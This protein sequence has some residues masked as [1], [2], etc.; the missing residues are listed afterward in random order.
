MPWDQTQKFIRSGHKKPED[1]DPEILKTITLSERRRNPSH[2]RQT[3]EQ[4]YTKTW[5]TDSIFK[6]LDI[7][8][9]FSVDTGFQKKNI[10]KTFVVAESFQKSFTIQKQTD[11]LFRRFDVIKS[12][13]VDAHFGALMTQFL[14]RPI[15]VLLKKL[16]AT[17]TF[18]LDTCFG[19]VVSETYEKSFGLSFIFAYRV[20]LPE[21][22]LDE[23][24]KLVLN[25]SKPYVWVGT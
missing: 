18:G 14:S 1:F 3:M 6:K 13:A 11:T 2:H 21:L 17:K 7:P 5:S 25:I 9:A 4:T 8:K 20:W 24:G 16:D 19:E 10:P 12:F 23:N 15:D 22:W